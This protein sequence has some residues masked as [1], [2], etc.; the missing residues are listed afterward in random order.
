MKFDAGTLAFEQLL[1][2]AR[3]AKCASWV[4]TTTDEQLAAAKERVGKYAKPVPGPIRVDR[5][6]KYY[7]YKSDALAA[8]PMTELQ[9]IRINTHV[10][11]RTDGWKRVLSPRQLEL[12]RVIEK[13]SEAKWPNAVGKDVRKAWDAAHAVRAK[14]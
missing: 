5:E 8:V 3:D 10:R 7:L 11:A 2:K 4:W 14:L 12:L 1:G 13:H 6:V 9:A